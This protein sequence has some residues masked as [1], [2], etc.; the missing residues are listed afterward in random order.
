MQESSEI[1]AVMRLALVQGKRRNRDSTDLQLS[2]E[3]DTDGE[4][5]RFPL[6]ALIFELYGSTG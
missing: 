4:R 3:Y 5:P 1:V 2:L 6:F